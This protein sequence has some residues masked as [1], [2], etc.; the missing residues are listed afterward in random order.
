MSRL[1]AI[2]FDIDDTLYSTSEFA[3][4]ARANSID[5]ML[6]CGVRTD[7]DRLLT[8]LDEVIS[9]FSSNY[10]SHFDKLLL[11]L[12]PEATSGL[13]PAMIIASA[14]VAYHETKFRE[15]KPYDDVPG[16]LEALSHSGVIVGIITAGPAVKQAEKLVRLKVTQYL[17]PRAIFISDQIGI[18][19]PNPK[20]YLRACQS[21][22]VIATEAMYIGDNPP[23]DIDPPKSLGMITVLNRRSGKYSGVPCRKEPDYRISS[24][25]ELARILRDDFALPV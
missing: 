12:P 8:E 13:N 23:N 15:L 7:R 5:A 6:A 16:I 20:L 14:V 2:F 19:K 21:V 9:E 11:R 17:D 3:R 22:G 18:S 1:A 25:T 24:F 10:G 4:R